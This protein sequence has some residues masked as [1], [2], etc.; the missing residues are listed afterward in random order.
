MDRN[1]YSHLFEISK[2]NHN[3]QNYV[4][5]FPQTELMAS[6]SCDHFYK[7]LKTLE[8][9]RNIQVPPQTIPWPGQTGRHF[10]FC[11][12][13]GK[14][15]W[16]DVTCLGTCE[17]IENKQEMEAVV[18]ASSSSSVCLSLSL[19]PFF[20]SFLSLSLSLCL[21]PFSLSLTAWKRTQNP[22]LGFF[23]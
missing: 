5:S 11:H 6:F 16:Q 1:C 9:N 15:T 4:Y 17:T 7:D 2:A 12:V 19:S 3:Q 14:E 22:S 10:V 21:S 18:G 20:V 8:R 13:G 23:L